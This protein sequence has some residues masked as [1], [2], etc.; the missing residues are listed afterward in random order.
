M[1]IVIIG[2]G[3]AGLGSYLFLLK[4]LLHDDPNAHSINIYESYDI[5]RDVSTNSEEVNVQPSGEPLFTPKAIG[6]AIGIGKNGLAVLSRIGKDE[7]VLKKIQAVGQPVTKWKMGTAR[8]WTIVD[9]AVSST[10]KDDRT[11]ADTVMIARQVAWEVLRDE[12]LNHN[13]G[14]VIKK[15]VIKLDSLPSGKILLEFEGGSDDTADLVIGADG[16]RSIVRRTMF[17]NT[18]DFEAQTWSDRLLGRPKKKKDY[19]TPHYEGLTGLGGF[20]PSEILKQTGFQRGS[21][22]ITF[23]PN[24]FFGH[25]YIGDVTNQ[26][27]TASDSVSQPDGVGPV[28]AWWSTFS[29]KS[30]VPFQQHNTPSST[31]STPGVSTK[32]DKEAALS[33]LVNRHKF[34]RDPTIKAILKYVSEKGTIEHT[35]PTY[36]TPELPTWQHN[37]NLVL[38]GDAAHALQPS[39]GQGACQ[40]LEDAESLALF[41]KHHLQSAKIAS[42]TDPTRL[43]ANER[44]AVNRALTSFVLLRKPRIA[45]IYKQSQKM[46]KMKS[47]VNVVVEFLMYFFIWL[48]TKFQTWKQYNDELFEYDVPAE[49]AMAIHEDE[50]L[51][52]VSDGPGLEG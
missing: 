36:T 44:D 22:A 2:A 39:S 15:K 42:I 18:N 26:S 48:A 24:G 46:S 41:L 11:I 35:Y 5:R 4:H 29:S 21:M 8:G 32:F 40:A 47:D 38:I 9:A 49:V 6:N 43:Q 34:W 50:K 13:P 10:R 28:A 33:S 30:P 51:C 23:G 45:K 12:V 7:E 19:I 25:G 31:A 27:S 1:R 3:I 52:T 16:L 17:D 20:V 37:G 14:A